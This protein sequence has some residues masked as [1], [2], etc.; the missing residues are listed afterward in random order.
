M[1]HFPALHVV[2]DAKSSGPQRNH[3][4]LRFLLVADPQLIGENDEPWYYD[5]LARWDSDRYL[6]GTFAVASSYVQPDVIVYLGDLFD[7]GL[8]ANDAQFKRYYERF[9]RAFRCGKQDR[10][11]RQIYVSGDN[12]IGGEY[13]NDRTDYL[14]DRFESYFGPLVDSIDISS[15][16]LELIKLD[17]DYTVSFYNSIK[18]SQLDA[19]WPQG[20]IFEH[21]DSPTLKRPSSNNKFRILLN[22]MTLLYKTKH[23]L[24]AVW[25]H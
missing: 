17:L 1:S 14:A 4:P 15:H 23:E 7:E 3:R 12:D 16:N 18:R 2:D 13:Y 21:V 9:T 20:G 25:E 19:A 5:W 22:H 24:N 6:R 11:V 10:H 8:A